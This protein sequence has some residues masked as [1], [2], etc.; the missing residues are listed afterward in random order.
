MPAFDLL[1]RGG[2]LVDGTGAPARPADVGIVGDRI[3]AVG[4]L[5]REPARRVIEADGR[6]VQHQGFIDIHSHS[7]I[8]ILQDATAEN[9]VRRG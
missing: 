3:V 6:C 9:A 2:A 8:G 5:A 4:D 7:D 1:I